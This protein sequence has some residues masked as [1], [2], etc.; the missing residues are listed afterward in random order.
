MF[1]ENLT[2][3]ELNTDIDLLRKVFSEE[4]NIFGDFEINSKDDRIKEKYNK[5]VNTFK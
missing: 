5:K 1:V 4:L 3:E 2:E